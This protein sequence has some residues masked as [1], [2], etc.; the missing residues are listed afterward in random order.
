MAAPSFPGKTALDYSLPPL[1]RLY[2]T[3]ISC[4]QH[5]TVQDKVRSGKE[6][7]M[8]SAQHSSN[9]GKN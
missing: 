9:D 1:R 6:V 3:Q 2:R 7:R 4:L 5:F 8:I